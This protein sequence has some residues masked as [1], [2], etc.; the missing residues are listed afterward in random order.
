MA[1][2]LFDCDASGFLETSELRLLVR[3]VTGVDA[4]DEQLAQILQQIDS[5]RDGKVRFVSGWFVCL[6]A[7]LPACLLL[8]FD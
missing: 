1:F 4:S 7:C 6:L 5:N 8:V 3:V 2:D